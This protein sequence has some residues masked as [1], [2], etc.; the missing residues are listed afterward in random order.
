MYASPPRRALALRARCAVVPLD[1]A[2]CREFPTR[3]GQA[4]RALIVD[5]CEDDALLLVRELKRLGYAPSWKR[6]E[7][8]DSLRAELAQPEPWAIVL[9]DFSLPN[10][11]AP[12]AL[13]IV[14]AGATDLPFIVVSGTVGEERVVELLR[15]GAHDFVLKHR[16]ARLGPAITRELAEAAMR[17][18][19]R[20]TEERLGTAELA[21][22]RSERL[23]A[24]GQMAAGV[25]HDLKNILNPLGLELELVERAARRQDTPAILDLAQRMRAQLRRGVETIER[26]RAFSRQSADMKVERVEVNPLLQEAVGIARPRNASGKRTPCRIVETYGTPP[27]IEAFAADI[28]SA[29]VNLLVN[30]IDAM[31]GGGTITLTSDE[32]GG[33]ARIRISDDGP[34]MAPEVERQAFEP[35]FTTKGED[36]T[37]LGLAMVYAS[38]LRHGG[39]VTLDTKPKEG[40]SFT[41]WFPSAQ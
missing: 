24:L 3:V 30:A 26:L 38:V 2:G 34:G 18:E 36:G 21:L 6:V 8:A 4:L 31:P 16:L 20:R 13:A 37:G 19:K 33:G 41:L 5:D 15:S 27:P 14:R 40:T 11:S 10:F 32:H 9:C 1:N 35:F 39:T 28:V 29:L 17:A 23:R 12:D 7:S 25:S 22:M